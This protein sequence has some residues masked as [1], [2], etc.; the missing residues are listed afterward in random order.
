VRQRLTCRSYSTAQSLTST[1]LIAFA[2]AQKYTKA[3]V[4]QAQQAVK[5]QNQV[6][7]QAYAEDAV[8]AAAPV[9]TA[10]VRDNVAV[11]TDDENT[12]KGAKKKKNKRK[13]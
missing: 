10:P 6:Q 9:A 8:P 11:V 3:A 4:D 1:T 13:K 12:S 5:E 2:C 7:A